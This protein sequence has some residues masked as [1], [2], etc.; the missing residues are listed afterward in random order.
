MAISVL[1]EDPVAVDGEVSRRSFT[2]E[3]RLSNGNN[4]IVGNELTG[5][6]PF[7]SESVD[8]PRC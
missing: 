6:L 7:G 5:L 1:S 4:V 2:V 3:F 8:V